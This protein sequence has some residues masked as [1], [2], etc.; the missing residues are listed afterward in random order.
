MEAERALRAWTV[1]RFRA[2]VRELITSV[3]MDRD[4]ETALVTS[5]AYNLGLGA[6][7]GSKPAPSSSTSLC[8]ANS[9]RLV[10]MPGGPRA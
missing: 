5:F 10:R 6:L 3:G 9:T 4:Q 8:T 2:G 7:Q 1:A